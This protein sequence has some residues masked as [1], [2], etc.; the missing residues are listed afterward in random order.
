[1]SHAIARIGTEQILR[2]DKRLVLKLGGICGIAAAITLVL[3]FFV[4]ENV[5]A[6]FAGTVTSN[7]EPAGTFQTYG[8]P[9]E[10][11]LSD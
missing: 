9:L 8:E 4:G 3:G 1:M 7:G 11:L 10:E 6:A 5:A 2:P